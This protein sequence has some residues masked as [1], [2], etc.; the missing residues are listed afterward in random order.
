[1]RRYRMEMSIKW[2][3]HV[4]ILIFLQK[5]LAITHIT[6]EESE[7]GKNLGFGQDRAEWGLISASID[8][9]LTINCIL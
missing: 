4:I 8:F 6:D 9:I 3:L 2:V 1:M 5:S 7:V